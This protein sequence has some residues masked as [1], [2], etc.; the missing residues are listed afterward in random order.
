MNFN[1]IF[2]R[3]MHRILTLQLFDQI[4][5]IYSTRCTVTTKLSRYSPDFPS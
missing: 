4:E 1:E 5:F 3:K 2:T